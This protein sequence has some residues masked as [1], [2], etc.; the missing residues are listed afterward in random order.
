MG[1]NPNTVSRAYAVLEQQGFVFTRRGLGCFV[2]EEEG[3]LAK[4]R[5]RLAES[6]RER[7]IREIWEL[8]LPSADLDELTLTLREELE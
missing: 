3:R 8:E 6:A 7:F 1:V 2:T 5:R 4:E